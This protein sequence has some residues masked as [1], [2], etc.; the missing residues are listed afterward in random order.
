MS[1]QPLVSV[2]L[3]VF[4]GAAFIDEAVQSIL[5][6]TH[7]ELELIILNDASTDDSK[8]K[9]DDFGDPRIRIVEN[10][11]NLGLIAT[12]N[13]GLDLARGEF[14]ARMDQDDIALPHRFSTQVEYM[15]RNPRVGL[16][17]S[18]VILF[19]A[20]AE[21]VC[22]YP[23]SH[24]DIRCRLL[25]S[26]A[27]AH[28]SIIFR[29]SVLHAYELRYDPDYP[30]AE[31]YALW[32]SCMD[33]CTMANIDEPLLRYRQHP[34]NTVST[35]GEGQRQC[36]SRIHRNLLSR[37]DVFPC[38]A[39]LRLHFQLGYRPIFEDYDMLDPVEEWLLRLRESNRNRGVYQRHAFERFLEMLWFRS[40]RS[41][42]SFGP[43]VAVRF[44]RSR[45]VSGWSSAHLLDFMKLAVKSARSG[46]GHA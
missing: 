17:G 7:S 30:H 45:L 15:Q 22:R 6:Q 10:E 38:D 32:V 25:F 26:T 28:P 20:D 24:E 43:K 16:C 44:F 41:L 27:F 40:C 31:D 46:G 37:L 12:L 4:N 13:K 3:P 21:R 8:D 11:R 18:Q 1:K 36:V 34:A 19:G 5:N 39:E 33:V 35:F 23:V 9:L 2:V 14:V 42:V 29:S